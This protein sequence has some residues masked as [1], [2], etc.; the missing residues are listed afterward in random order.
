MEDREGASFT[1]K[2]PK[3]DLFEDFYSD[4]FVPKSLKNLALFPPPTSFKHEFFRLTSGFTR[5]VMKTKY[6]CHGLFSL[7]VN[8]H[9]KVNRNFNYKKLL[10]GEKEKE[11]NI[12]VVLSPVILKNIFLLKI[13]DHYNFAWPRIDKHLCLLTP[14]PRS[15]YFSLKSFFFHHHQNHTIAIKREV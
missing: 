9:D 1:R 10:V 13:Y 15:F 2:N 3:F 11:P 7:H 4:V 12:F 14:S 8:F 6:V 5:L